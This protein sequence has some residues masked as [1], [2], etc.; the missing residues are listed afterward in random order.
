MG[1]GAPGKA[2]WMQV[3]IL[4]FKL[5]AWT[6]QAVGGN[7]NPLQPESHA[8]QLWAGTIPAVPMS[9]M[10]Q[11]GFKIDC[12]RTYRNTLIMILK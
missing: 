1:L 8:R 9:R 10:L 12:P 11:G 6:E 4:K 3:H 2:S 5:S 7:P